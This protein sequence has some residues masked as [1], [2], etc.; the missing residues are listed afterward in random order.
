MPKQFNTI[1]EEE[2][3]L[4]TSSLVYPENDRP[5]SVRPPALTG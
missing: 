4:K 2:N 3:T 1:F 5:W